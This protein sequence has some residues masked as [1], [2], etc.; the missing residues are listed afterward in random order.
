MG[1]NPGI[2]WKIT[3]DYSSFTSN[4]NPQPDPMKP[5]LLS[6]ARLSL[7]L[8]TALAALLAQHSLHAA[9]YYW[10]TNTNT[11][12][13]G[14]TPTGTW[15]SSGTTW[16]TS[17]TG[18][19]TT[20]A[21]TTTAS[22]DLFFSAGTDAINA[23]TVTLTTTQNA[24]SLTFEEGTATI[25]GA[26]GVI[27][28][29][30]A[31]GNITVNSGL[32]ATIGNNTN[33]VIDGLV[34]LTKLGGG[35]LTLNGTATNTF[36]GGIN[37][38]GGTLALDFSNIAA[39][40]NLVTS[41]ALAFA[42]GN[43]T[44]K[45]NSSGATTQTLGNVTVNAGGGTLLID[46]NNGTS[47]T[48]TLG[49]LTAT[50]PGGSLAVGKAVTANTG[51][52]TITT[53]TD[54]DAT[55]IYGGRIVFADGTA[56]TG[57]DWAT[58][59][60][61]GGPYTLSAYSGYSTL[62]TTG[63][64]A[65]VNYKMTAAT[66]LAGSFS[67]NTLKLEAPSG[68]LGLGGN[69]LTIHGGGLLS[70]GTTARTITGNTGATRLTAGSGS[71][72]DLVVHQYNSGGLTI[73]AVIGN[74]AAD[75]QAVSLTKAGT[76]SLTL[77]GANTYSGGTFIN[78]GTL[79]IGASS[80][81]TSGTVISGPLGT[82][83]VTLAGGTLSGGSA[84]TI[85]NAIFAAAGTSSTITK[86]SAGNATYNGNITGSGNLA[87][88]GIGQSLYLSGDNSGY[89]GTITTS[90]TNTRLG[91]L[92]SG[93]ASAS[94]IIN[95]NTT[96]DDTVIGTYHFGALSGSGS[97]VL[98]VNAAGNPTQI[99]SIGALN[100]NT[101]YAGV[102]KDGFATFG[103]TAITKVGSGTLTLSNTNTYTGATKVSGG[104]LAVNGSISSSATTVETTGILT[105]TGNLGS[106]LVVKS[107][108]VVN[109]GTVGTINTTAIVTGATSFESGSIF[110]WDLSA[111][112]ATG[113]K[114]TTASVTGSGAIFRI[115][116]ADGTVGDSFFDTSHTDFFA[117]TNII[118]SA[119]DLTAIFST[120]EVYSAVTNTSVNIA[121][122]GAFSL[123]TNGL[124]WT[125]IPEPSTALAGILLGLGLLRRRRA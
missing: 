99:L 5:R 109:A 102:I 66:T 82:G 45:G 93:S 96:V 16:S 70:T 74:N 49:S 61:G 18:T 68:D 24:K 92:N 123:T 90:A 110:S 8:A 72:Y 125:A 46:P 67:V 85:A 89:T 105:G 106:S 71:N 63:G 35:T 119:S 77:S 120:V 78:S 22:D 124:T 57:Y 58:N 76:G 117:D 52:V 1:T 4:T 80:T 91:K 14:A 60:G 44:L 36:T 32:T 86:N 88:T 26:S 84:R 112:G 50:A 64:S 37:V 114:L 122:R 111:D 79:I 25:S 100:T 81:P 97:G 12:G 107:T 23:F 59:T 33:T 98:S 19:S 41:Q 53:T 108:G 21:Y 3:T 7:P 31:G 115:L 2:L 42:G 62:P 65:S 51:T 101:T 56:N 43:L 17:S 87:I 6:T 104:T 118:S 121:S 15:A 55:G 40:T 47:T 28:L 113:D 69:L 73:G 13:A 94:W 11:T 95:G 10:D 103:I 116:L 54:K 75:S 27:T 20:P 34:G 38:N 9:S 29:G 30:G 39:S 48:L 83:T